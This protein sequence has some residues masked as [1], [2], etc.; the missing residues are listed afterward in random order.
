MRECVR[1]K[2]CK[3]I[4]KSL[5]MY[6]S[7]TWRLK[8]NDEHNLDSFHRQQLRTALHVK[9][10]Y[11]IPTMISISKLMKCL[12]IWQSLKKDGN[13]LITSFVFIRKHQLNNQW[14]IIFYHL[15]TAVLEAYSVSLFLSHWIKIWSESVNISISVR[16]MVYSD[17][18]LCKTNQI[19]KW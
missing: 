4:V 6:N 5:P 8:V 9:F 13:S 7:Q 17:F 18:S 16:D 1:V 11:V 12:C 15:R 2:L 10:P 3:T 19:R 14:D